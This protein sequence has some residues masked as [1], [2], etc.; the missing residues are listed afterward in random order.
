MFL[1]AVIPLFLF[2]E[3]GQKK[4][5]KNIFTKCIQILIILLIAMTILIPR[6]YAQ[7]GMLIIFIIWLSVTFFRWI[8]KRNGSQ[9]KKQIF[10]KRNSKKVKNTAATKRS[11]PLAKEKMYGVTLTEAETESILRHLSL[12]ISEKLKS[13]YPNAVW[14]WVAKPT[15]LE[16]LNGITVRIAVENMDKYTHADITFDRFERIHIEPMSIGS[17]VLSDTDSDET[18]EEATPE[19]AV[20]DVKVWY[21]LVGRQ[22]L[23]SQITELNANGYSRLTIK[24][25]GDITIKR[26]KKE[27]FITK[28]ESFPVKNYWDELVTVF[29]ENELTAKISGNT[30]LISWI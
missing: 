5:N 16:L 17:F 2:Q 28:L 1:F 13:A 27:V 22:M 20:I 8:L 30:L 24:E 10:P 7:T 18:K 26:Q 12:R 25:N 3:K 9:E 6:E 14:Q 21:E 23:E 15:L 19:P 29:E 11:A 4:M